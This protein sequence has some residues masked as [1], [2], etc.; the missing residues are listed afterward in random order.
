MQV[1]APMITHIAQQSSEQLRS[2]LHVTKAKLEE[3]KGQIAEMRTQ[4]NGYLAEA[5]N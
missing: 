3:L 5:S 2:Y 4:V 1:S